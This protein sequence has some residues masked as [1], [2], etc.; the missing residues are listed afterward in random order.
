MPSRLE[1]WQGNRTSAFGADYLKRVDICLAWANAPAVKVICVREQPYRDLFSECFNRA[2]IAFRQIFHEADAQEL[3]RTE[4]ERSSP[5]QFKPV[6]ETRAKPLLYPMASMIRAFVM[7]DLSTLK[8]NDCQAIAAQLD[9][10]LRMGDPFVNGAKTIAVPD[11]LSLKEYLCLGII[12]PI[13]LRCV[14]GKKPES[15]E[16]LKQSNIHWNLIELLM[17]RGAY[18]AGRS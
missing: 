5:L 6:H 8:R 18:E 9:T 16:E 11:K 7:H 13:A 12:W 14:L 15:A 2:Q 17:R 10:D 3:T 1:P 4:H